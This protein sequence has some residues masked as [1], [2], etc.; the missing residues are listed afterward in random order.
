MA[1][2][3]RLFYLQFALF[4]LIFLF[5]QA[6]AAASDT[7]F[8]RHHAAAA[9]AKHGPPPD[10][11]I[12]TNG[13]RLSGTLVREV[14]GTVTFQSEILGT[15]DI[16][17]KNIKELHT[18]TKMAVLNKSF[19]PRHGEVPA[20]IPQGTLSVAD[21][22]VTVHPENNATIPPIPVKDAQYIIDHCPGIH[23][24][25][26]AS[27]MERLPTEVALTEQTRRF[28]AIVRG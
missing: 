26:G 2:V 5:A 3:R 13:D 25:Y 28:K 15:L 19:S 24:F 8:G 17:W 16:P 7:L 18:T 4:S 10:F 1:L 23:G 11:I 27:S 22:M 20:H 14:G 9:P 21:N 6:H 12:F